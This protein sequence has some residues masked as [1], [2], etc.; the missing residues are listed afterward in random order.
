MSFSQAFGGNPVLVNSMS[1]GCPTEPFGHD[2]PIKR[3]LGRRPLNIRLR[4]SEAIA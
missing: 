3:C 1:Y 2:K 4:Y